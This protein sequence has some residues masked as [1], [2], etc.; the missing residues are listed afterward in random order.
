MNDRALTASLI[1]FALLVPPAFSA[2]EGG[3]VEGNSIEASG[4]DDDTAGDDDDDDG[5]GDDDDDTPPPSG[6]VVDQEPNNTEEEAQAISGSG[7][8]SIEGTC[9]AYD[10][11]NG[12]DGDYYVV[13]AGA[14]TLSVSLAWDDSQEADLDLMV[15]DADY[16]VE[17]YDDGVPPEDS[18]AELTVELESPMS[19]YVIVSCYSAPEGQTYDATVQIP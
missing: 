8:R 17:A 19:L 9:G 10:E 18:P 12:G 16:T 14:G 13:E 5:A 6:T 2:C 15:F 3:P 1:V 11:E 4:D 7:A